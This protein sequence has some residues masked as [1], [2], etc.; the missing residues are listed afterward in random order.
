[1]HTE[2]CACVL[3]DPC[4]LF[5]FVHIATRLRV[6]PD[7]FHTLT[8]VTDND[9]TLVSDNDDTLVTDSHTF[10]PQDH[11]DTLLMTVHFGN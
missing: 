5:A 6:V 10:V 7:I 3:E 11:D 1:M 8:L 4:R 2:V 9:D